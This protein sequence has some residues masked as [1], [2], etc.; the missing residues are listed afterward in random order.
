MALHNMDFKVDNPKIPRIIICEIV[1]N[2][3]T[4]RT[5]LDRDPINFLKYKLALFKIT[6]PNWCTLDKHFKHR[7][8]LQKQQLAGSCHTLWLSTYINTNVIFILAA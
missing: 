5:S 1:I 6:G 2:G 4:K 7:E 3:N 8:Y